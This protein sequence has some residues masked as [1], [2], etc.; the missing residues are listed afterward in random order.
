MRWRQ[1]ASPPLGPVPGVGGDEPTRRPGLQ[2]PGRGGT[3]IERRRAR[4]HRL[5]GGLLH[6]QAAAVSG[7]GRQ[8]WSQGVELVVQPLLEHLAIG[9]HPRRC[10]TTARSVSTPSSSVHARPAPCRAR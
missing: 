1:A 8:A 4:E 6:G 2:R 3:T 9:H 7:R 5:P 10:R